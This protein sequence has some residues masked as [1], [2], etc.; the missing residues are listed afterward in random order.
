M[1]LIVDLQGST[2]DVDSLRHRTCSVLKLEA[3]DSKINDFHRLMIH[4]RE[5]EAFE[6][7]VESKSERAF[8]LDCFE[9]FL[10]SATIRLCNRGRCVSTRRVIS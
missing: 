9:R 10:A 3:T 5:T 7:D 6:V 2:G 1:K 8:L 4:Q